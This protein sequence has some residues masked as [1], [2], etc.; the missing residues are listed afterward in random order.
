MPSY[1]STITTNVTPPAVTATSTNVTYDEIKRSL[2]DYIYLVKRLYLFTDNFKQLS[3]LVRYQHY[4]V[5]GNKV[6]ESLTPTID[7]YQTQK[8]L[9]YDTSDKNVLLDGQSSLTFNL[10]PLTFIKVEFFATKVAKR[11]YLDAIL[12]DANNF[13]QLET[14]MGSFNFFQDW[15]SQVTVTYVGQPTIP[16]KVDPIK[17]EP[18]QIASEVAPISITI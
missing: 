11:D 3:G 17:G 7:P 15:G 12:P 1:S 14:A 16:I 18:I 9:F 5:N 8:S 13:K 2:G 4:D 10:L 6:V